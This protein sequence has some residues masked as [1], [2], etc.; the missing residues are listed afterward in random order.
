MALVIVSGSR[1]E[2]SWQRWKEDTEREAEGVEHWRL[3]RLEIR[4]EKLELF[5]DHPKE[6]A[7]AAAD[8]FLLPLSPDSL[9]H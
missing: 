9:E 4:W 2:A 7:R 1:S 3:E 5:E 8:R 6:H